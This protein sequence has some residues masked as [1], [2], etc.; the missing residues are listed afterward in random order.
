MRKSKFWLAAVA[1]AGIFTLSGCFGSGGSSFKSA[2]SSYDF[3]EMQLVQKE[4]PKDGQQLAVIETTKGTIKA[5]LYPEYAPNTV[6]NFVNRANDG[7]YNGK[8]IYAVVDNAFFMAGSY[9]ETNLSGATEDGQ[10]IANEYSVNLWTFKGAFCAY[11]GNP[12]YGDSRFFVINDY[13]LTDEQKAEFENFTDKNGNK[14]PT[15]VIEAY[16]NGG[17]F[18][19]VSGCYTVFAQAIEGFDTIEAIC[20]SETDENTAVPKEK[21]IIDKVTITEYH[22]SDILR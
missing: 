13:Q 11:N 15:E 14:M 20:A 6:K 10:P 7:Y 1:A 16:E 18:A 5:V 3:T 2:I 21:I 8:D 12:G 9:D 4:R 19:H 22:E 17:G